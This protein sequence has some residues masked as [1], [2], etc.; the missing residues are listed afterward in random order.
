MLMVGTCHCQAFCECSW[1]IKCMVVYSNNLT[2]L[3]REGCRNAG[4]EKFDQ[5]RSAA[6]MTLASV[7]HNK[8]SSFLNAILN[9]IRL[10]TQSVYF[11]KCLGNFG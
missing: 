4:Q 2:Y 1:E 8:H 11:G 6:A 10:Y 7:K 9:L 3:R 5:G